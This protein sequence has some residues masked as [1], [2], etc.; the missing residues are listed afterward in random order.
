M[1]YAA[2]S[3]IAHIEEAGKLLAFTERTE[4]IHQFEGDYFLEYVDSIIVKSRSELIFKLKCGLEL[5][6]R[7]E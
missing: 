3:E 2:R 5:I 4:R 7:I 1:A 6:E